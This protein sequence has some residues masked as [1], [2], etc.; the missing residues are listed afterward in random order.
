MGLL[1]CF[2]VYFSLTGHGHLIIVEYSFYWLQNIPWCIFITIY[3][4]TFP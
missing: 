2:I 1:S 3:L 4:T